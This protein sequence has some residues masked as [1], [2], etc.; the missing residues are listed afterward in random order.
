MNSIE[1]F[2]SMYLQVV[3]EIMDLMPRDLTAIAKH[4]AGWRT[5]NFDPRQYLIDS[6]KR[7]MKALGLIN[8]TGAKSILDVGGFMAAFPL[9]L[10]RLGFTVSIAEKFGYYD[11]SL[12]AIAKHLV[13]NGIEVIDID[14]TEAGEEVTAFSSKFDTVTCMAVAEHL[15]HTPK[16]LFENI[17][18]VLRPEG[19]L[20][21]E[22]PN[23]A[24]WP[25]R[26]SFFL[27]GN[28]VLS[29]IA[30]VYHSAIPY[31]GHHRE[32]TLHDA[33]YVVKESGFEI[34]S[35][36]TFNYSIAEN[37]LWQRI[38]YAP[39]FLFKEWAEVIL[40]HCRQTR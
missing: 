22:V 26:Y 35:E 19:S 12:D 11:H 13:A 10:K 2:S 30:E 16:H 27:K 6:E 38:K 8:S 33:R 24:Y 9:V 14:F 23:L 7:Y 36:Q 1:V 5:G 20:I 29:P 21:F 34:I 18:T 25:R 31:T 28:S 15:A 3:D 32:Y 39:A 37:K 40:I 17:R 4:N